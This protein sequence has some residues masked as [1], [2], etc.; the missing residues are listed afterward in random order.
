MAG[1][2]IHEFSHFSINGHTYDYYYGREKSTKLATDNPDDAIFN[3]DNYEYF[4]EN[5]PYF[6]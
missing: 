4:A 5:T 3:A 6:D 2:L 1:T